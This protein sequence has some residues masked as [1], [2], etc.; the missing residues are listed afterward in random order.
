MTNFEYH[1]F[2]ELL[3]EQQLVLVEEFRNFI[4]ERYPDAREK[5][6]FGV[7]HYY[8]NTKT[9]F[10]WPTAVPRSGVREDGVLLGFCN[11][12]LMTNHTHKFRGLTNRRVRFVVYQ[13]M[14]EVDWKEVE[15]WL[16]EVVSL[17]RAW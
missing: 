10:V 17:D 5:L 9:F 2:L 14:D 4:R 7:P 1:K 13:N 3:P 6:T 8:F 16:D 15:H 11:G 12:Y